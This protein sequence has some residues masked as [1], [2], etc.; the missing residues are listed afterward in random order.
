MILVF[1][2]LILIEHGVD[3]FE[4]CRNDGSQNE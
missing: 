1:G 4:I 2:V 3:G